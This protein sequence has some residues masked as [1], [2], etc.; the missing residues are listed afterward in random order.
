[1]HYCKQASPLVRRLVVPVSVSIT[2]VVAK[3]ASNQA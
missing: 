2:I 1:V 3:E